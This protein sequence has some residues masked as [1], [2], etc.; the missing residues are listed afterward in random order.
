MKRL[1]TIMVLAVTLSGCAA[2]QNIRDVLPRDHD[3]AMVSLWVDT[4]VALDS[5]D[6]DRKPTGWAEVVGPARKLAIYTDFRG[7]PQRDNIKGLAI[8]ADKMSQGGSPMFCKLGKQTA[9]DRLAVARK[10]WEGR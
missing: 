7:D 1:L 3:P 5:V 9:N 10:A 4:K 8:H 6:C 2:I